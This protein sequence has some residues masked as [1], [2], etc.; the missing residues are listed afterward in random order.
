MSEQSTGQGPPHEGQQNAERQAIQA[1]SQALGDSLTK[2]A[3]SSQNQLVTSIGLTA[4]LASLP[5]VA[6]IDTHR[7]GALIGAISRGRPDEAEFRQKVAAFTARVLTLAKEASAPATS[8]IP[9]SPAAAPSAALS[10]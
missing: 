6:E 5:G 8:A 1:L 10:A 4:I 3:A 9:E 2:I 7:L